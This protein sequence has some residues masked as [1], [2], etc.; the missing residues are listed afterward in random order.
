[1]QRQDAVNSVICV[2]C[3]EKPRLTRAG[4][5]KQV[6]D[7][8]THELLNDDLRRVAG[9]ASDGHL[10]MFPRSVHVIDAAGVQL[11]LLYATLSPA[12]FIRVS[13][14]ANGACCVVDSGKPGYDTLAAPQRR[15]VG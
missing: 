11:D 10:A 6:L 13:L 4:V 9:E 15:C 1:M 3:V 7:P 5:V 8:R 14:Y 2:Q 12:K